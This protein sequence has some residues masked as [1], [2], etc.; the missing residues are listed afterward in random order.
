MS[1]PKP[2]ILFAKEEFLDYEI[3][4][5]CIAEWADHTPRKSLYIVDASVVQVQIIDIELE[6]EFD[7]RGRS[8]LVQEHFK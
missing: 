6:I 8:L 7:G 4:F 5:S 2:I 3:L 1:L